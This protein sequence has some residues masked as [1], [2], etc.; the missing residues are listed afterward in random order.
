MFLISENKQF[1]KS[2]RLNKGRKEEEK[3]EGKFSLDSFGV[4]T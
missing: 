2:L 3:K 1:L 4:F